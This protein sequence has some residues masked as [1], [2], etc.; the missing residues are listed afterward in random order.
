MKFFSKR[1]FFGVFIIFAV[2]VVIT[3]KNLQVAERRARDAQRRSDLGSLSNAV[4]KYYEDF[5]FFPLTTSDGSI[6]ACRGANYDELIKSLSQEMSFNRQKYLEGLV[7]CEW[8][9]ASL[10]DLQDSSYPAYLKTIPED[11]LTDE[12]LYYF[13]ISDGRFYQV[14]AYLEGEESEDGYTPGIVARNLSCGEKV[15]N[16]GKAYGETPLDKSLEE[17][18]NEL[19]TKNRLLD[20]TR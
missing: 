3:L 5:G 14:Y 12:G 11:P 4:G 18:E 19:S 15:C 13:Y 8:G 1:E 7:G 2:L 16:F 6:Q 9:K 17:Y 20:E 10:V